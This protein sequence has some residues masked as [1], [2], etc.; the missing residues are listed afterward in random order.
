MGFRIITETPRGA[1]MTEVPVAVEHEGPAAV[2]AY[3][4]A[5]IERQLA[6]LAPAEV[7]DGANPEE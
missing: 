7:V 4:A 2:D 6:T 5:D 1:I 3:V